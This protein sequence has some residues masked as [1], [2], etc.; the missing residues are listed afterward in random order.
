MR[1]GERRAVSIIGVT[2]WLSMTATRDDNR[3][4]E[5]F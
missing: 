2:F 4:P 5:F 1:T 3:F